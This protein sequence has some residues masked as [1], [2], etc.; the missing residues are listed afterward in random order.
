MAGRIRDEDI[1]LVRERSPIDAVVGEYVQLRNAGGGA[2]KGLCPFH[3]E[4]SPS[5]NVSNGLWHCLAGE[6]RVLTWQGLRPIRELA[7]GTHRILGRDAQWHDAPFYSFGI[8]PLMRIVLGRNGQRKEIYATAE[9]RWFVRAGKKRD[10]HRELTTRELRPDHRLAYVFPTAR[11]SGLDPSPFGIA[12]G[13]TFGDGT[14]RDAGSMAYLCGNKDAQL[15]KWFPYSRVKQRLD[16]VLCVLDLPAFFKDKPSLDESE[17]YLYG[18]LA[19]YVAA[20]GHVAKDGTAMLHCADREILEYVRTLC[21]RL[22]IGTYGITE[23]VREGFPGREPSSIFRIHFVNDDLTE[24]FFLIDEHRFRFQSAAKKFARRGWVVKSVEETGRVEEVFCAVVDEGHAFVL[25]D[26]ILTGNC[27]GCGEGGDAIAFVQKIDHLSFAEAI[28][29]LAAK[30]G[31]QLR[32]T[33]GGYVP[34]RQKGERTRLVEAHRAAAEFYAERLLTPAAEIGRRFLA[35]RGFGREEAERFGVGYAPNEW[36]ALV[37]HLRGRGFS[38]KELITGGLASQGRRGPIDRFRGRLI[39]PIRDLTGDVVGFGARRLEERDDGPKYLNTPETPLFKKG[40]VLYGADLAKKEIA[41]RRQAV[42]VEGYT[43]VM[44][45]HLAGVGTAIATSG[46]SFGDEHI[47]ILRRLLM[48]QDEASGEVIFTFD[49][50]AAGQKAA[51]RAFESEH[52]FAAQ[53]FVAVQPDGLD[54]CDLRMKH[55]DAAVRDLVASRVPLFRFAIRAT[56]EKYDLDTTEGRLAAID[57]AAPII[58][59]IRDRGMRDRYA[60]DLDKWTG[61]LD[62]QFVLRRVR[63][64]ASRRRGDSRGRRAVA[65]VAEAPAP[66]AAPAYDPNDP[67][68]RVERETLKLAVQRP[69]LLGPG[70]DA[71]AP[72]AMLV[73]GHAVVCRLI[74][75]LGGTAAATGPE[76]AGRLRD[77]AP[78]DEVRALV[79]SL[80]VEPLRYNGLPDDRYAQSQLSRLQEVQ[81][82]REIAKL[83]SKLG[84]LNPVEHGEEHRRLFGDLMALEQQRHKLRERGI[85]SL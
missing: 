47:K 74:A 18:W 22:G 4:K 1:A 33:E 35:E 41:R 11:T 10:R 61:F 21:A 68:V 71:V 26:N 5:F 20:D 19:G 36:E 12:H 64:H 63:E 57:A 66:P 84:R 40:S 42:I 34:G 14:R 56:I 13:I 55:G 28:E 59:G 3:D 80:A 70:F 31:V 23:Q 73:P 54:P 37:R 39:W 29:R 46:T 38:D 16:G 32:Y 2:L 77:A 72:D 85:G 49:G 30:A 8:Q 44:A 9:H 7:G 60:I 43:D 24:D 15:L 81:V 53:T 51:L 58:A 67:I 82:T 78:N 48:D 6:T 17:S 25:E 79:T 83:Q 45:C 65:E 50:D 69:A 52:K 75:E 76:W 62:E 27:F